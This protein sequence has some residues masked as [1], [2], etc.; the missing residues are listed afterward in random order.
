MPHTLQTV[1][2]DLGDPGAAAC[3]VRDGEV[4]DEAVTG[5]RDGSRPWTTDTLV[6]TYSC[7]KPLAA[8]TVLTAV[9]DGAL[10]LDQRVAELWPAYAAHGKGGTTVRHVLSHQAG[11]PAFPEAAADVAYDDRE[12]LTALLA[13]AAPVHEPGAACAEHA[14]TY[15]HLCDQLVR[16]ATGE[17]LAE[18]F[19]RVAGEHGWDLHL[20]V[21][22][23][24][25]DRVADV[26]ALD[27]TWPAAY[28]DDPRWAPAMTRPAGLLDPAELNRERWRTTAFPAVSLHASARGLATFYGHLADG[29]VSGLLGRAL[30]EEYVAPQVTGH[31][32][33]LD[34]EVTW[35]LGFQVDADEIGMGG[36]GGSAG[37]WS[38]RGGYAAAYV[39]RGLGTH[40]RSEAVWELLES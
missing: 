7:A 15:G 2:D 27:P 8:L 17:G 18:R 29:T 23:A 26:V 4:V 13:D 21:A 40:D 32:L 12:A 19:A 36:A 38:F 6:L 9:R 28:V 34:R 5:T 31:D 39:T 25:L 20:R 35:T 30:H 33:L 37:W 10:G 11:L 22:G 14:L 24:D 16:R 3:V 1:L